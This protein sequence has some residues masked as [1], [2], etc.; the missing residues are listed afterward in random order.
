MRINKKTKKYL[1]FK[2]KKELHN[3]LKRE[4]EDIKNFRKGL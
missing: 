1:S 3:F 2:S 4:I